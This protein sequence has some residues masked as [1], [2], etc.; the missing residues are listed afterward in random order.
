MR[1]GPFPVESV[2]EQLGTVQ[3]LRLVGGAGGLDAALQGQP[4]AFP[5]AYVLSKEDGRP[6]DYSELDAQPVEVELLVVLLLRNAADADS[7]AAAARQASDIERA[8]R[9]ALRDW[10]PGYPFE[11]LWFLGNTYGNYLGNR[12][13]RE[14]RFRCSY[15]DQEI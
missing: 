3:A 14:L 8:I 7:G 12:M 1:A 2:I 15:R 4:R 10:S 5:A 13:L 9:A 11:R 6:G